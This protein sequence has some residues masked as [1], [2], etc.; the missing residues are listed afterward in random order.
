MNNIIGVTIHKQRWPTAKK[1]TYIFQHNNHLHHKYIKYTF[2]YKSSTLNMHNKTN[3]SRKVQEVK[4]KGNKSF[5]VSSPQV[6]RGLSGQ[7]D[8]LM[9]LSKQCQEALSL[10]GIFSIILFVVNYIYNVAN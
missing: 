1:H 2:M 4:L 9:I 3:G 10:H 7:H 8:Y 6:M 5:V